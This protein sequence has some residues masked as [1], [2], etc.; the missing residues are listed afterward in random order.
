MPPRLAELIERLE[1]QGQLRRVSAEVNAEAEVT[2][3]ASRL[4]EQGEAAILFQRVAGQHLPLL[5]NLLGHDRLSSALEVDKSCWLAGRLDDW[6]APQAAGGWRNALKQAKA[7]AARIDPAPKTVRVGAC[8]QVVHLGSDVDLSQLPVPKCWPG[9]TGP[10]LHGGLVLGRDPET[11]ETSLEPCPVEVLDRNH[12]G[13]FLPPPCKLRRWR[14]AHRE[15]GPMPIAV[16]LGA[17]AVFQVAARLRYL[18]LGDALELTGLLQQDAVELA[19][20]RSIDLAVP[21]ASELVLEGLFDPATPA[22]TGRRLGLAS[23]FYYEPDAA[24]EMEVTAVTHRASPVLSVDIPGLPGNASGA[25]AMCQAIDSVIAP[26]VQDIVPDVAML[27]SPAFTT[28]REFLFVGL[29]KTYPHQARQVAAALWGLPPFAAVKVMVLVDAGTDPGRVW[30]EVARKA[31]PGRD[32]FFHQGPALATDPAAPIPLVGHMMAIDA[33]S[34]LPTE[35]GR[36]WPEELALDE[37]VRQQVQ[38][39][40]QEFGL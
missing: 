12:A 13:V 6:F 37:E 7:S 23:G 21:T 20:A 27:H 35:H 32:V 1:S 36:P 9:D 19:N 29:R 26:W 17:P 10:A 30:Q 38:G 2:A 34:K 4:A 18:P 5:V 25:W 31:H 28:D 8:Q 3:I 16:L 39:R 33:T 40:W 14:E 15:R 24:Y 22:R 11:G